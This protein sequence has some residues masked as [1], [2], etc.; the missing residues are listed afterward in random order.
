MFL[1]I[2]ESIGTSELI[3]IGIVALMFLGPR[4]LPEIA[5]K[6]GK[7]TSEFRGTAS[8]FKQTWEREVSFEEEARALDLN[9]IE[10]E[11]VA[12]EA[13]PESGAASPTPDAPTIKQ[14]DPADFEH[15]VPPAE[16]PEPAVEVTETKAEDDKKNWL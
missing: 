15:M 2:L 13:K 10:S 8:E 12:R 3:L 6:I 1:F 4:K 14:M 11:A 5:R 7:I 16:P 9:T